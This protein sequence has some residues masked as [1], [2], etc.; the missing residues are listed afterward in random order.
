M[1]WWI[2][3]LAPLIAVVAASL[4]FYGQLPVTMAV[5]FDAWGQADG[6]MNKQMGVWILPVIMVVMFL[7][8][9]GIKR[10]DPKRVRQWTMEAMVAGL[11]WF[12]ALIQLAVLLVNVGVGVDM[13][14]VMSVMLGLGV[15]G[16]GWLMGKT[17]RNYW[18]G[19]RTPW[20]LESDRVWKKTNEWGGRVFMVVGLMT[21]VGLANP[22]WGYVVLM[23]GL[24]C[25][26]IVVAGLS[27][28]WYRQEQ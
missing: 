26:S 18:M 17:K 10:T 23:T 15:I 20:T 2:L 3:K 22:L 5:H 13:G 25:G 1:M 24:I 6:W 4:G 8:L 19:F 16:A 7:L 27:F 9:E 21:L 12:V 28:W 11:L 14:R